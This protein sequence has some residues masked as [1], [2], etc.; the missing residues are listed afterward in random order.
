MKIGSSVATARG[1]SVV[2]MP[3]G[4]NSLVSYYLPHVTFV[5][6]NVKIVKGCV[7]QELDKNEGETT[8][9]RYFYI[10]LLRAPIQRYLS[11]FRW[12]ALIIIFLNKIN[13][14]VK[15]RADMYK[16]ELLGRIRGTFVSAG[17]PQ[18]TNFRRAIKVARNELFILAF[19]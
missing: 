14:S 7:D 11:E 6:L 10:S 9:R 17:K 16:E 4:L 15:L 18:P 13:S 8:K 2:S 12:V 5:L 3:I 1:G 19:I